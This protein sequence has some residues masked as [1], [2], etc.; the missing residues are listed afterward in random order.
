M[1]DRRPFGVL[2][3]IRP[4]GQAGVAPEPGRS[5][6]HRW[7]KNVLET[8]LTEQGEKILADADTRAVRIERGLAD[9]FTEEE[10]RTLVALLGRCIDHLESARSTP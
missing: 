5:G 6:V 8:R 9:Q 4:A 1:V 2:P 3:V 10:R 7:H